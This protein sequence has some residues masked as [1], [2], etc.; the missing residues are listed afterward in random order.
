[1]WTRKELKEKGKIAFK[2]NYWWCVLVSVVL[3]VLTAV[4]S[5]SSRSNSDAEDL[6]DVFASGA[7][8]VGMSTG[9]FAALVGGI[10]I[11]G[12]LVALVIELLIKNVLVVGCNGFFVKNATA[13]ADKVTGGAM[14][15]GFKSN[16]KNIVIGMLMQD[17]F[18]FL[19]SLLLIIPGIVKA[20]EYRMIP[21][22]L[23]E[24]P[25]MTWKDAFA[26]S[27]EMMTG[28]KWKS[29]VLDLSFI[30]WHLLGGITFGIV[31]IFWTLPYEN[32]TDAELYLALK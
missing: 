25:D 26:K 14:V 10:A 22:L 16:Y 17:V 29:F 7:A 1:M 18:I 21:Y 23:S 12:V 9:G 13:Y 2:A 19:W 11:V 8:E 15:D 5:S 30:G 31:E 27:K 24:N 32:A 20:Y 6:G 28:N 3:A 4:Q